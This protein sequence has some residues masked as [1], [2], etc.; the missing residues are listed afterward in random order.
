[1]AC[2]IHHADFL[3]AYKEK[4]NSLF[5][6]QFSFI[7]PGIQMSGEVWGGIFVIQ[8]ATYLSKSCG[9]HTRDWW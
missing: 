3:F 8:E 5:L 1:M 7:I 4:K 6:F 2:D 9:V